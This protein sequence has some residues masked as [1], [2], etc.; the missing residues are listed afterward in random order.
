V[1]HTP[2]FAARAAAVIH[3]IENP[4][5]A[6]V[7]PAQMWTVMDDGVW[8]PQLNTGV[9]ILG[10]GRG[11]TANAVVHIKALARNAVI[12]FIFILLLSF[13]LVFGCPGGAIPMAP[14][15]VFCW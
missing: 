3:W 13:F 9:L 14:R 4:A 11:F 8:L 12:V 6:P 2:P 15:R 5:G 1:G 7:G 10:C